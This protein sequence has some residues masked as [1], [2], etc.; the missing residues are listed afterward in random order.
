M[1]SAGWNPQALLCR[2]EIYTFCGR[3]F[4]LQAWTTYLWSQL[5]GHR[6]HGD[7]VQSEPVSLMESFILFGRKG[8]VAVTNK[9]ILSRALPY[10]CI[11]KISNTGQDTGHKGQRY[12]I[13]YSVQE[14]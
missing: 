7:R 1:R 13:T 9:V 5:G 8:H 12:M 10:G 6:L 4:H 14:P 2:P 11:K 3:G